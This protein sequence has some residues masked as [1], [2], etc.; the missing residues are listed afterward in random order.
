MT[1][2]DPVPDRSSA[3]PEAVASPFALVVVESSFGN[4]RAVAEAI[5]DGIATHTPA[6][7][8]EVG[9]APSRLPEAVDLLVVGGPT[10]AFGMFE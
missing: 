5:R 3:A 2:T 4:T 9:D 10:Q 6:G 1:T 7:L 8:V